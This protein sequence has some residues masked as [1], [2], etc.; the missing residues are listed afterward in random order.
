MVTRQE[1]ERLLLKRS[2]NFL[3]TAEYQIGR[4]FY[5]LA[6]FSLEQALQLFLKAKLLAEGADY[7]RTHS[8]RV[9]LEILSELVPEDKRS[10]VKKILEDYLLELGM[11][12][13]AYITSRYLMREF[14]RQE[15]EKLADAVKEIIKNV[16]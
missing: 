7:P 9:L 12:E 6:A 11:L 13:D 3:E 15:V 14:T 16:S 8:V 4:G 5:D 10:C 1:E 2:K